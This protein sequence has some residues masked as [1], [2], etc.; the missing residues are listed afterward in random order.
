[1]NKQYVIHH[2]FHKRRAALIALFCIVAIFVLFIPSSFAQTI[3]ESFY[4]QS[5]LTEDALQ[6]CDACTYS[7]GTLT[8]TSGATVTLSSFPNNLVIDTNGGTVVLPTGDTISSGTLDTTTMTLSDGTLEFL[9][10]P[11]N[12]PLEVQS[13]ASPEIIICLRENSIRVPG[14]SSISVVLKDMFIALPH[15]T[16]ITASYLYILCLFTTIS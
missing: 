4:E 12:A 1:M 3:D 11:A 14:D 9:G 8:L 10:P 7:D 15:S 16:P 6:G 5:G 2:L 13:N